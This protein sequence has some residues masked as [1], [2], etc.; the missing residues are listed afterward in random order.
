MAAASAPP[1]PELGLSRPLSFCVRKGQLR[2]AF[3]TVAPCAGERILLRLGPDRL[4]LRSEF[5]EKAGRNGVGAPT[6]WCEARA[7]LLEPVSVA[8][9][10]VLDV[11]VNA[12]LFSDSLCRSDLHDVSVAARK[13]DPDDHFVVRVARADTATSGPGP[14]QLKVSDAI[15]SV[16]WSGRFLGVGYEEAGVADGASVSARVIADGLRSVLAFARRSQKDPPSFPVTVRDGQVRLV[17]PGLSRVVDLAELGG[18][19][20]LTSVLAARLAETLAQFHGETRLIT[21]PDSYAFLSAGADCGVARYPHPLSAP[22]EL[23]PTQIEEQLTVDEGEFLDALNGILDQLDRTPTTLRMHVDGG[24]SGTLRLP[25]P[26]DAGEAA[27][28]CQITRQHCA[29]GGDTPPPYTALV[30]TQFLRPLARLPNARPVEIAF[31]NKFIMVTQAREGCTVRTAVARRDH[32]R[33]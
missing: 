8:A 12:T 29:E 22:S 13:Q 1:A 27:I 14:V 16:R 30:E 10:T 17:R 32:Q 28:T 5:T 25:V 23:D 9:G 4:T 33:S 7:P 11:E 20:S 19:L 6:M 18:D 24:R 26:V 2:D 15:F 21:A 3:G 31:S